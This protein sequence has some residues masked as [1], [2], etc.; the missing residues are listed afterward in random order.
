MNFS[1]P[2]SG[3]AGL[4]VQ[5]V[6]T[7]GDAL[8]VRRF[9][10]RRGLRYPP[11]VMVFLGS[12]SLAAGGAMMGAIG[13]AV[14]FVLTF[15]GVLFFAAV[16]LAFAKNAPVPEK[17]GEEFGGRGW[18]RTPFRVEADADGVRYGHGPFSVRATWD[19]F[20]RWVE[21]EQALVLLEKPAAGALVYAL[22]KRELERAGGVAAWRQ[23]LRSRLK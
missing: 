9:F 13:S 21:T 16:L 8:E 3:G 6:P 1:G 7:P 15:A 20:S 12:L 10:H 23:F 5:Y 19:A 22:P 4:Q 18:L 2:V 17:V 11:L 14:W